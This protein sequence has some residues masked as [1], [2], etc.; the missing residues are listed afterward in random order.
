[1]YSEHVVLQY[2]LYLPRQ[3]NSS[4]TWPVSAFCF[5]MVRY[6]LLCRSII[7]ITKHLFMLIS[8]VKVPTSVANWQRP[9]PSLR[10]ISGYHHIC[11]QYALFL[12]S[13]II[14]LRLNTFYVLL[15][16]ILTTVR[17]FLHFFRFIKLGII[18]SERTTLHEK[19]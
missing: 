8:I 12:F 3:Y 2:N 17:C 18:T 10:F 13:R 15:Y 5:S 11:W 1:M 7:A 19:R 16:T 9:V 4:M 6:L 14:P